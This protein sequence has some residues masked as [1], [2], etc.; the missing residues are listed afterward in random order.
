MVEPRK[1]NKRDDVTYMPLKTRSWSEIEHQVIIENT[2]RQ[3]KEMVETSSNL[4]LMKDI[5]CKEINW[6][7]YC[8]EGGEKSWSTKL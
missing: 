6:V 7:D 2:S 1:G 4:I 5:N 8:V 3:L